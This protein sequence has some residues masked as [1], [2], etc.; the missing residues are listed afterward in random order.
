MDQL[1]Q[2]S[3]PQQGQERLHTSI[4]ILVFLF[5]PI[6]SYRLLS[7][8]SALISTSTA[9]ESLHAAT[10]VHTLLVSVDPY[11][12]TGSGFV[13]GTPLAREFW[14]GMR[15]GGEKG[16]VALR[17]VAL[18]AQESGSGGGSGGVNVEEVA[19]LASAKGKSPAYKLK[20]DVYAKVRTAL[21]YV[22][23]FAHRYLPILTGA[24]Q[25]DIW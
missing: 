11:D 6:C 15:G 13:G 2:S 8:R 21:R 16:A 18:R 12:A 22:G 3:M 7:V 5:H 10:G 19:A 20:T 9:L 23:V 14:R 17:S 25:D 24:L 4:D 1:A